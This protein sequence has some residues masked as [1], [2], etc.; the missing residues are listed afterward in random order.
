MKKLFFLLS[1]AVWLFAS[2]EGP[3]GRD[4]FDGRDGAETYWFV[5]EYTIRS[6]EWEIVNGVNELGSYF[7]K[8]ISIPA[9]DRD[10]YEYGTVFCYMFQNING[11]EVQTPLQH[12]IHRGATD[13]REEYL[14]SETY[15]FVYSPRSITFI[16]E[17]SNFITNNLNRPNDTTFRVVLN[18]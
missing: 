16:V 15:S 10:I 9:L 8:T 13:G 12:T 2:C 11:V 18:Y 7:K 6:G 17:N 1:A 14:W 4:G 5:E 3:A